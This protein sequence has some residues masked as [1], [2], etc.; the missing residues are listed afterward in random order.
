MKI[1]KNDRAILECYTELFVNSTPS[2]NFKEL[3][4]NAE[5]NE[6][7]Q[8]VIDF[9]AYEI[10]E[11]KYDEIIELMINKHKFKGYM[12]Q[13]FKNTIALGCSPKFKRKD[14]E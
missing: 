9:M 4:D 1:S 10:E 14:N 2:A 3:M 5:I 8:K 11:E 12:I 13:M 6:K 7:G